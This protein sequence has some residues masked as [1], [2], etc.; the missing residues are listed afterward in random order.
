L[1]SYAIAETEEDRRITAFGGHLVSVAGPYLFPIS[2][3]TRKLMHKFYV[4]DSSSPFIAGFDLVV[5]AHL[6]IDAVGRTVYTRCPFDKLVRVCLLGPNF[7]TGNRRR[8][9]NLVG[10]RG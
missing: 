10:P 3:L 6:I 9:Y 2:V 8:R 4:I 1:S 7:A 5:A